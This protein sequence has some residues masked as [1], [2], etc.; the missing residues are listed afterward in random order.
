VKVLKG[1]CLCGQVRYEV[2]SSPFNA[3]NCH[4]S[5]CRRA[6]GAASVAWFSTKRADFRFTAGE[7]ARYRSSV[8]GV[9]SFCPRCGTPL[10]FEDDGLPDELDVTTCTL[11]DPNGVP[12]KDHTHTGSKLE[13]VKLCDGLKEYPTTRSGD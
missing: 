6:S 5:M 10:T 1:G 13:W 9:R 3:T 4:C 12:P 11:D 7:P 8:K 2:T